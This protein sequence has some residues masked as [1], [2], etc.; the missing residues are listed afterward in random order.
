MSKFGFNIIL[1]EWGML[2]KDAVE[3][4]MREAKIEFD[5]N[6]E[7]EGVGGK[8][9]KEVERR[10][11]GTQAYRRASAQ[12]RSNPI[13][14]GV[15]ETLKNGNVIIRATANEGVLVNRTPYA[16]YH[17]DGIKS[18]LPQRKF[19][20]QTKELTTKQLEILKL[21]TGRAWKKV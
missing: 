15:T 17:Q 16:Q 7:K 14:T 12:E 1:S 18:R 19:I 9:W 21:V 3:R 11:P 6:F 20:E 10:Q 2:K 13:L 4:M 8:K 5:D